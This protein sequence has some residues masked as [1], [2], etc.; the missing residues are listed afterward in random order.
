MR[1]RVLPIISVIIVIAA[2]SLGADDFSYD[3]VTGVQKRAEQYRDKIQLPSCDHPGAQAAAE[4]AARRFYSAEYQKKIQAE[5]ERLKREKFSDIGGSCAAKENKSTSRNTLLFPDERIYIFVSS[6][7]PMATLRAYA[8]RLDR[9]NDPNISMVMRG[10]VKGMKYF[11]PTLEFI[12]KVIV[13]NTACDAS[14]EQCDAYNVSITIDP[15]L[16]RK[17]GIKAVP[18]IAYARGVSLVD[19]TMSEGWDEN[20]HGSPDAYVLYGDVSLEYAL[21][22]MSRKAR[23]NRLNDLVEELRSGGFY[24]RKAEK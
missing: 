17:Y 5:R 1:F 23:D 13:R 24:K 20:L 9:I 4:E 14:V 10:F 18:A 19:P 2:V 8:Q 12:R 15:V 16:F 21:A 22:S 6:S 7:V 11:R 3:D